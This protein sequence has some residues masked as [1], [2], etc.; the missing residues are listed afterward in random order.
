VPTHL[1]IFFLQIKIEIESLKHKDWLSPE[2][3]DMDHFKA[4]PVISPN[5]HAQDS[6][7]N[8]NKHISFN[9]LNI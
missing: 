1:A 6:F 2:L 7:H 4:F 9:K 3:G 8:H 5:P